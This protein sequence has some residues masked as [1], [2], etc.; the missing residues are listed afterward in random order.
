MK[1]G[2]TTEAESL[3]ELKLNGFFDKSRMQEK[4]V[5]PSFPNFIL[6]RRCEENF[7]MDRRY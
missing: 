5:F 2:E 7:L 1:R 6:G 4:D 3:R